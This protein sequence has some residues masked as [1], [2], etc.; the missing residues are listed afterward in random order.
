MICTK[1]NQT[2]LLT[3]KP[4]KEQQ[5]DKPQLPENRIFKSSLTFKRIYSKEEVAVLAFCHFD[6]SS[7]DCSVPSSK[8]TDPDKRCKSIGN[9]AII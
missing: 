5:T 3:A 1:E 4:I 9:A 7:F 2:S 8:E 6:I